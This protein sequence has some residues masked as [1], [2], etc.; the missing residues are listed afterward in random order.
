VPESESIRGAG[1]FFCS[2][3]H[4]RLGVRR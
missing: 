2:D 4:R 3:E 1:E